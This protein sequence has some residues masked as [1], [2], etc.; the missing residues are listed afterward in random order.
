MKCMATSNILIAEDDP[1]LRNLYQKKFAL[2]G[3]QI[4]TAQDGE[5]A[6]RLITEQL[7][8]LLILDIQM[9]KMDGFQVLEMLPREKRPFPVILLSNLADQRTQT[10]CQELGADG[11]LIKKDMT[12][13]A[14]LD[15]TEKLLKL[16]A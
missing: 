4:R 5:E 1:V 6:I 8:D 2:T 13:K 16:R 3:F 12:I 7:P 15:L 14:L 11:F 10:R 9:P